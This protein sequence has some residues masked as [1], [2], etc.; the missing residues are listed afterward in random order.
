MSEEILKALMQLFAIIS[1]QGEGASE[2]E[3]SYVELFLQLQ[4]TEDSVQEYLD[5]YDKFV[6]GK[7]KAKPKADK[8]D[9][10]PLSEA[11]QKKKNNLT[12][13]KDS[14]RTL[15]ICKKINKTLTQRQKIVVLVRLYELINA[16]EIITEQRLAI[17]ETA[18]KVF[19]IEAEEFAL[20]RH[21]VLGEDPKEIDNPDSMFISAEPISGIES[22]K[23]I[24]SEN[25][26]GHI[27]IIKINSVDLYF[28]KYTGASE[29]TLNGRLINNQRIYL[30][31]NGSTIRTPKG[32]PIYYSDV[33]MQYMQDSTMVNISFNVKGMEYKHPNGAIGLHEINVSETQGKLI[34]L[35]GASGAG[36]TT[37]LNVMAGMYTPSKGEVLLNSINLH[38]EPEKLEGV[39]GYIPQDDLLIEELTVFQNLFYNA[40]LC[41]KDY[42]DEV[43]TE[44]VIKVLTSLG[45]HDTRDLRV[46][47]PLDKTI[48]GGQRKRLNIALELIREPSV[49]FV[50]EP[51]S[52]LSSRDSEN[53][54]DLLRE[55]TLKGKLIF[56][57]IHQPSSD[58]YKMFDKMIILDTGGW[59]SY[60]GN[61]VE[62]MMY[63]RGIDHQVNA[64]R[65]ECQVC[66]TVTPEDIFNIV[67]A[68]V[69]DEYGRFTEK[70]KISPQGWNDL[71]K[72]NFSLEHKEDIQDAPPASLKL[73]SKFK[74]FLIFLTRDFLAKAGN[75][76][77][78]YLN[79]LISPVLAFF[80]S[81]IIRYTS[82]GADAYTFR[83]NDNIPAYIFMCILVSLFV[84]LTVSAEEIYRDQKILKREAFLNLSRSGYLFSKM[85]IL[86]GLSAVQALLFT[87]IGNLMLDINGMYLDFWMM[88]FTVG[89]FANVLGLN[90]SSA[91]NSPVTIY[92]LIP[93][94]L[95]PQMILGGAMFDYDKLNR[96]LGGEGKV[97]VLAD[98]MAAR[99]AYEGLVVNQFKN[100][101]FERQFYPEEQRES[102]Y[103]Y[104]NVY[105][106]PELQKVLDNVN[107]NY[108]DVSND[109][110]KQVL[111][112]DL[113]L[114]RY[115]L[116]KEVK[117]H[118]NLEYDQLANLT[119]EKFD[120]STFEKTEEFL[121]MATGAY[122]LKLNMVLMN[123]DDKINA[124]QA[125]PELRKRFLSI[126]D[127]YEN[128]YLSDIVK[129]KFTDNKI[130][131][132]GNR[133]R[134]IVGPIY[135][136]PTV[137]GPL[138]FRAHFYAPKK[139]L[140]GTL[141]DT[142]LFNIS[143]LWVMTILLY[144]TLYFD[145]LKK[146]LKLFNNLRVKKQ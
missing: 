136:N 115:E 119:L 67:E 5:L 112:D 135:K 129:K 102:Y 2:K 93:I 28:T 146:S 18:A 90:I 86:F 24:E 56:V 64:D 92:I 11:E 105:Y 49:L 36:K 114:L 81:I 8:G 60:Y 63:Y 94:I 3:R 89:C 82:A 78:V 65:G 48:S 126:R 32:K 99:W 85:A 43:I 91:F 44:M 66:G 22:S 143:V 29:V 109:S 52:G 131:R 25:L 26:E 51:T 68:K 31:A 71:Y 54:M 55:L 33:A 4:L 37:L 117:R 53:V 34:G 101:V 132:D 116:G 42:T 107:E 134:Q 144:G 14:V 10:P 108:E 73:P 77:Y 139:H 96:V 23:F 128:E 84:G 122:T 74:Q 138:D 1:K 9:T 127:K 125:N 45:L 75:K 111:T 12:S 57:V 110:I 35:M 40:K 16:D 30:F 118:K 88:L 100:N 61:P 62:A 58:I 38:K 123:K 7:K 46:G 21:F 20:I 39:I 59:Q 113:E 72:E 83:A 27:Y 97:P 141:F 19:N 15:G 137:K 133:L 50:D 103:D 120:E 104:K 70:R 145:L 79:L 121:D 47:S 13:V 87:V 142:F 95:I 80:L 6:H 41:F 124:A 130:V 17:V 98:V 76:Q 69:V 106:I 140:F